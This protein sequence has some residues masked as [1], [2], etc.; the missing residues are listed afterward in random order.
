MTILGFTNL[1]D[2]QSVR[3]YY[4]I[5]AAEERSK[6]DKRISAYYELC[7][8]AIWVSLTGQMVEDGRV[9]RPG[10]ID[11]AFRGYAPNAFS[12]ERRRGSPEISREAASNLGAPKRRAATD[13]TV[14]DPKGYSAL[15]RCAELAGM[16]DLVDALRRERTESLRAVLRHAVDIGLIAT[17]RGKDGANFEPPRDVAIALVPHSL[18]RQGDKNEHHHGL[19]FNF[20]LTHDGKTRTLDLSNLVSHKFYLQALAGSDHAARLNRMGFATV[21]RPK[22]PGQF[23]MAGESQDLLKA[24]SK[25]RKQILDAL[26][27][28]AGDLAKHQAAEEAAEAKRG[29]NIEVPEAVRTLNA[30]GTRA[31]REQKDRKARELRRAKSELPDI[32]GLEAKDRRELGALGLSPSDVVERMRQAATTTEAPSGPVAEVALAKLFQRNSVVTL[33]RIRTAI[34]EAAVPQALTVEQIEAE[35][36]RV[37]E[38][39]LATFIG[40]DTKGQPVVSTER[41]IAT[42][43]SMLVTAL[44]GR[45]RGKLRLGLTQQAIA[46]MEHERRAGGDP[47]FVLAPEQRKFVEW[48]ARGDAVTVGT[49]LAGAGKTVAMQAV[50]AAAHAQDFRTIG[51]APTRSAAETLHE[52]AAT[53]E[54]MSLQALAASLRSGRRSLTARDFVLIDE[55]GMAGLDD[56]ATIVVAARRAGAQVGLVGDEKQFAA[57]DP[58]SPFTALAGVLG[59]SRLEEIRRQ[60]TPWQLE[61]SRRMADGDSVAGLAAYAA[62]GR[63]KI[64]DDQ[65]A[66]IASLRADWAEDLKRPSDATGKAATRI[67]VAARHLE[68]HHINAA[69]RSVLIEGGRLGKD[70]ITIRT[71]HRDGKNGD[72]RD[73]RLRIGDELIVWRNTSGPHQLNNGDII[74]ITGFSRLPGAK[75][76]DVMLRWRTEKSGVETEAPLSSLVP[77]PRPDDPPKLPR[78][79]FLQHAYAVTHYAAQG[80]T[81]DRA[82]VYGGTGLDARSAYVALTRHRD[83]AVIYFDK[84]GISEALAAEGQPTTRSAIVEHIYRESQRS[85]EKLNVVDFVRDVGAWLQTGD[86]HAEGA[87]QS[88]VAARISAAAMNSRAAI[89]A[90]A[91]GDGRS[92][93]LAR[94]GK[95]ASRGPRQPQPAHRVPAEKRAAAA[96]EREIARL[97]ARSLAANRR[98]I[99]RLAEVLRGLRRRG[100][101]GRLA[102]GLS[103]PRQ[104][105]E[106]SG[107]SHA[108]MMWEAHLATLGHKEALDRLSVDVDRARV[109]LKGLVAGVARRQVFDAPPDRNAWIADHRALL[110][111]SNKTDISLP[112]APKA[113]GR[114]SLLERASALPASLKA[115]LTDAALRVLSPPTLAHGRENPQPVSA[116]AYAA[117]L[118]REYAIEEKRL[119]DGIMRQQ[120]G[121]EVAARRRL[122]AAITD[123]QRGAATL[124]PELQEMRALLDAMT[125]IDEALATGRLRAE[126]PIKPLH[127][128]S[129]PWATALPRASESS[130]TY[131]SPANPIEDRH[132]FDGSQVSVAELYA[133]LRARREATGAPFGHL[134]PR[135]SA[136]EQLDRAIG[137]IIEAVNDGRL[138]G[139]TPIAAV[140]PSAPDDWTRAL[141]EAIRLHRRSRQA[142]ASADHERRR[143]TS[144][145]LHALRARDGEGVSHDLAI[146]S[147]RLAD[148]GPPE[149]Q[150]SSQ[151]VP[152]PQRRR[153]AG[154]ERD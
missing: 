90:T 35:V 16:W 54:F 73:L 53:A 127:P 120:G 125:S 71:L 132:A 55:A 103:M 29:D 88:P 42:E 5:A 69:L 79:P 41:A 4:E 136:A 101:A 108:F 63:W 118:H 66:A 51:V 114:A 12:A 86:V 8:P 60:R 68:V 142:S 91:S 102:D 107:K 147:N 2:T 9:V 122:S 153:S 84:G 34:A 87:V 38:T 119:L 57:I 123:R 152:G 45:G 150:P 99:A 137:T 14:S 148:D 3:T 74:R 40:T 50:V 128:A 52:E 49:G 76:N 75:T 80:K 85:N 67:V 93:M 70:E 124:H 31:R 19:V 21:Q 44:E 30:D 131:N 64:G 13:V 28:I 56:V 130:E 11:Q 48:F 129:G 46:R 18:S 43:R 23:A 117:A 144:R 151:A 143:E 1:P 110:K 17:R 115:R 116:A 20:C 104:T 92:G 96:Y 25:G 140:A 37:F 138:S 36:Q 65:E 6:A 134:A 106:H 26:P 97:T 15:V 7:G 145:Q 47:K 62:E 78:V 27:G 94:A 113:A 105:A 77:R 24:W 32:A 22:Q 39:G 98:G 100:G 81:V 154:R 146:G 59:T 61:A 111:T 126:V 95:L 109:W 58:G 10:E 82:F 141:R 72:L 139:R 33:R 89:A 133:M 149:R 112:L 83:D 121:D 135:G